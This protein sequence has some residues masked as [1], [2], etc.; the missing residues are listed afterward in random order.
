MVKVSKSARRRKRRRRQKHSYKSV[1]TDWK[2]L[3]SNIRGIQ[4]KVVSFEN[5]IQAVK[6]SVITVNET[7]LKGNKR[8]CLKG[9]KCYPANRVDKL[10]GGI[11]TY[12]EQN[13]N[14]S[15][16][17]VFKGDKGL[18]M[19]ITRHGQFQVPINVINLYGKVESRSRRN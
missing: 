11:A 2:L 8:V 6:P 4:S 15:A 10:G 16:L 9:Y 12:I 1:C 13:E 18:E 3:H 19:L 14:K 7:K 17:E 5:I